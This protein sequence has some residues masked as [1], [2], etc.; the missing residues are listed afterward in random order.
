MITP[1]QAGSAAEIDLLAADWLQR[2]N[3]WNLSAE[4]EAAFQSWLAQSRAHR[5]AYWRQKA[6]WDNAQRLVALRPLGST[7]RS[8]SPSHSP[9][10][11]ILKFAAAVITVG[12][13]CAGGAVYLSGPSREGAVYS[14]PTG[15]RETITLFDGSQVELNTNTSLRVRQD[16]AQRTVVLEKGEA[17]FDI[18]HDPKRPF[19]VSVGGSR[20]V[21]LGTKFTVRNA[22]GEVKVS[23]LEGRA[24]FE[25][26]NY[27]KPIVLVPGDVLVATA[28]TIKRFRKTKSEL[29]TDLGWRRGLLTFYRT[30]LA[31]AAVEM[32]RYNERKIVVNDQEA[33]NELI[34]GTF[35]TND[36]DLFG[37]VAHSVLGLRV[38]HKGSSVVITR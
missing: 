32:N 5:V 25:W 26:A 13:I 4:D 7:Y 30:T 20:V 15:G 19:S 6:V 18:K 11:A 22:P 24:D 27:G 2:R 3:F 8:T 17:F 33:A 12:T 35:P 29:S 16:S 10:G 31:E 34:D 28:K 23:L 37:R 36:V 1:P 9:R 21:D 14:T 38:N